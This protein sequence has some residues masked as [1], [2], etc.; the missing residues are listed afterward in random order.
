MLAD[1][2]RPCRAMCPRQD[3][4]VA[5]G[6]T[7]FYL[8]GPPDLAASRSSRTD[9]P[10]CLSVASILVRDEYIGSILHTN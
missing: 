8:D 4:E 6:E 7:C 10:G 5:T 1:L 9:C 3:K 2:A